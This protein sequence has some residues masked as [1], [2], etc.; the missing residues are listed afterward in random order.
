MG[1]PKT[2]VHGTRTMYVG[3]CRCDACRRANT[4]YQLAWDLRVGRKKYGAAKWE[5]VRP[6]RQHG[7]KNMYDAGCR[8]DACR[9]AV[10]TYN[11]E[12]REAFQAGKYDTP[13][14]SHGTPSGY[15]YYGCRCDACKT[16][17]AEANKRQ[18][19]ARKARANA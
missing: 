7:S 17:K 12:R 19:E 8:C 14:M 18:A 11:R 9:V 1:R 10:V 15:Q 3:G 6:K 4:E 16:W 5:E 13:V 2:A